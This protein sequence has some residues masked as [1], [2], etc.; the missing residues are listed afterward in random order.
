[1]Q[2]SQTRRANAR[3][4][5]LALSTVA[6]AG[7]SA[8]VKQQEQS[9]YISD[10]S[11]LNKVADDAFAHTQ[12]GLGEYDQF[13]ITGPAVVFE[14]TNEKGEMVF[15]DEELEEL[16]QYYRERLTRELTQEAEYAVVEAAGPGV[17]NI[18]IAITALDATNGALNVTIYT[19]LTGAGL[20]GIA[21]EDEIVD[22][23]SGEQLAATIRWGNGSRILRAGFTRLGDAKL[24]INRWVR[25]LRERIDAAHAPVE[26]G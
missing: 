5:A 19:K 24:K 7:C 8:P 13:I 3:A 20:G 9:G 11:R 18:R 15:S 22:S 25:E 10:Y 16:R 21:I 12:A 17:A 4:I 23:V 2:F 26:E 1:M 6:L 14:N